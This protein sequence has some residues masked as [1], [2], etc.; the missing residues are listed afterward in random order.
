[1]VHIVLGTADPTS[2]VHGYA[3]AHAGQSPVV[4]WAPNFPSLSNPWD[5]S[6]NDIP[7][8]GVARPVPQR[9]ATADDTYY[10]HLSDPE[11]EITQKAAQLR[12]QWDDSWW[13]CPKPGPSNA[14]DLLPITAPFIHW[15]GEFCYLL[16][17]IWTS[18]CCCYL[19]PGTPW[20]TFLTLLSK[21][22]TNISD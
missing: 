10:Y 21:M 16:A 17:L 1:M 6:W 3:M 8:T 18:C 20:L 13:H 11:N 19:Q 9:P 15:V 4:K 22:Y 12:I 5:S 2:P 14:W 7:S